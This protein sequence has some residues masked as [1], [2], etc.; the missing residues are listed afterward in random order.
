MYVVLSLK[1]DVPNSAAYL[2]WT[3]T[4]E[5][6]VVRCGS[7][8]RHQKGICSKEGDWTMCSKYDT[9]LGSIENII[10]RGPCMTI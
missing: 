5:Q 4:F 1:V 8:N 6:Y 10:A 2:N 3:P 9:I 7:K